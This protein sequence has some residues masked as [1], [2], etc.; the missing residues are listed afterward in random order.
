M[1]ANSDIDAPKKAGK[2]AAAQNQRNRKNSK[3][4]PSGM[5]IGQSSAE[6]SGLGASHSG[7]AITPLPLQTTQETD[8]MSDLASL[9]TM[10]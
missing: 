4:M 6:S 7:D 5:R 9:G 10:I 1:P 3:K 2:K 8:S